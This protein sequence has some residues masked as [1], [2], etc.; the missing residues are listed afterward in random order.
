M[1]TNIWKTFKDITQ[2]RRLFIGKILS[3]SGNQSLVEPI[4]YTGDSYYAVGTSVAIGEYAYIDKGQT[5]YVMSIA[6]TFL[7]VN[8]YDVL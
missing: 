6:P 4:G 7:T 1:A 5:S 3:Y 2:S 8:N